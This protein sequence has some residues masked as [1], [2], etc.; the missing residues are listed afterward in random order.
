[1]KNKLLKFGILILVLFLL[2]VGLVVSV[3]VKQSS[4]MKNLTYSDVDMNT[5]KDGI[6]EGN[7]ETVFVKVNVKVTV[8]DHRLNDIEIT[9]HENGKGKPAEA[10]IH[11]MLQENRCDVDAVSGATVSSRVIKSAVYNALMQGIK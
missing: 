6:Y 4:Q 1:M 3:I 11:N 9:R 5:V 8:K 2:I 7:A 10:I